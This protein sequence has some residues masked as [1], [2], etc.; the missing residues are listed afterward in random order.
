MAR[1]ERKHG[2]V[3]GNLIEAREI[4]STTKSCGKQNWSRALPWLRVPPQ[5]GLGRKKGNMLLTSGP[6]L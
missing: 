5:H 6:G 1:K 3:L 4:F 2:G